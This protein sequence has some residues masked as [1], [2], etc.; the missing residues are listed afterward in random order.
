MSGINPL[1]LFAITQIRST[2]RDSIGNSKSS[3]GTGF[4]LRSEAGTPIFVTNRHNLD[5]SLKLSS[6]YS[7]VSASVLLRRHDGTKFTSAT[8]FFEVDLSTT[9]IIHSRHADVSALV[10]PSFIRR[11]PEYQFYTINRQ[12]NLADQT[13]FE[14]KVFMMDLVSFLG[15]PGTASSQWWDLTWNTPIARLA[16]L[17]SWPHVPFSNPQIPTADITLVSGLS[18]SGSSGS[19][20]MLHEKGIPPGDIVDPMYTPPTIIGIMSGHWWEPSEEPQMF[21]H[22]GL[23]YYTRSTAISDLLVGIP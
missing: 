18:F 11:L 15:Y 16:S 17:A 22:S 23:S 10:A 20:V 19:L 8:Q 7:L 12:K 9:Q 4:F 13:L 6:D 14:T 2:F 21:R 3:L 1:F 5:P